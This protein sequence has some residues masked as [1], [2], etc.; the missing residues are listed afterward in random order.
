MEKGEYPFFNKNEIIEMKNEDLKVANNMSFTLR[1]YTADVPKEERTRWG[2]LVGERM[3]KEKATQLAAQLNAK[4][5]D[6]LFYEIYSP[7]ML[8]RGCARFNCN[9]VSPGHYCSVYTGSDRSSEHLTLSMVL[10]RM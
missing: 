9:C 2:Y 4:K 8:S 6:G 1:F 5:V 7:D 10:S 3:T